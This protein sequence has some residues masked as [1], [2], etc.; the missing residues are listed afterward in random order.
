MNE[1][2][3]FR[4]RGDRQHTPVPKRDRRF[5]VIRLMLAS[6][7]VLGIGA[8]ITTAAWTDN[9]FFGATGTVASFDL[10]GAPN[11]GADTCSVTTAGWDDIGVPGNEAVIDITSADFDALVPG[12]PA[13]AEFCLYNA[14][15][16][17]GDLSVGTVTLAGDFATTDAPLTPSDVVVTLDAT[18]ITAAGYLGGQLTVTPPAS[19]TEAAFGATGTFEFT[20]TGESVTP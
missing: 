1:N 20:V 4:P 10:Q 3:E 12:E 16:L 9:V 13:V 5:S 19:W 11:P 17:A 14:G 6:I 18:S 15:T 8:V 7:A 2:T